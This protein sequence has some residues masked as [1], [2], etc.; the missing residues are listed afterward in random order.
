MLEF[1]KRGFQKPPAKLYGL[2]HAVLN[3]QL[4][5]QSMWMNMGY[6]E[7]TNDFPTAC[8]ALLEQVVTTALSTE[9]ASYVRILDVGCG[10]GDQSLY[11]HRTLGTSSPTS[12]GFGSPDV[13]VSRQGLRFRHPGTEGLPSSLPNLESYIGITLEKAQASFGSSRLRDLQSESSTA[14]I[15]AE[16]FCADAGNPKC[17]TGDLKVS[18]TA[19]ET[20]SPTPESSTWLLALDTMYHFR[21]TRLPLLTY[22][23][24]NLNAN[25]MAFDLI[26]ADN[27]PWH[28]NLLLRVLC[29]LTNTPF[30]N[31]VSRSEYVDM[32]L[33]AGY[34]RSQ[35]EM[36]DVTKFCFPGL[37]DFIERRVGEGVSFGLKM[38]K[39]KVA[40][41]MFAWWARGDIVRGV[42]VVAR[43]KVEGNEGK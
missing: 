17:W 41:L 20:T 31:L 18:V 36:R 15:P 23:Q 25:L 6:W 30:G 27:I 32:L 14:N 5:P 3:I 21:P 16:I 12:T 28:Q 2:D 29:W 10:C 35:I 7:H 40:R 11:L 37:A 4:P 26:M 38:G 8:E 1:L 43:G 42:I 19:L 33:S 9:N 39:F 24:N 22:A 13:Q 34:D